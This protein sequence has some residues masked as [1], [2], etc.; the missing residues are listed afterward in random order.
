MFV[1]EYDYTREPADNSRAK[2]L[3]KELFGLTK[4][5]PNEEYDEMRRLFVDNFY[6]DGVEDVDYG[7]TINTFWFVLEDKKYVCAV[8]TPGLNSENWY[9]GVRKHTKPVATL[10]FTDL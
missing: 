5:I 2:E 3:S 6:E 4:E 7:M 10:R 9:Y 8:S 1:C